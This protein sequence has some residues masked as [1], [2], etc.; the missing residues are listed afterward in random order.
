[1]K[2]S[3]YFLLVFF[4]VLF[5]CSSEQEEDLNLKH[6][7]YIANNINSDLIQIKNE[8]INLSSYAQHKIPFDREINNW[9]SNKYYFKNG[10]ILSSKYENSNSAVYL[11]FQNEISN[12]LKKNIV[13][14]E[15]LDTIFKRSIE[16]NALLTQVY[17]LDTNS[18]LRIY[19]FVDVHSYLKGS[20]DLREFVPYQTAYNK[21]FLDDNVYWIKRP[22]ADPYGRGWIIAC[23]EPLYYRERFIGIISGNITLRSL[24]EKYFSSDTEL[25][26]LADAEGKSICYTKQ[27]AKIINIPILR[28]FQY[29]KPVTKDI[30]TFTSPS[31][32]LHKNAD[33][34]KAIKSLLKGENKEIFYVDNKKY[35]IYKSYIKETNWVL[36]K[37]IN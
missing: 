28:E 34:R 26:L 1:M 13:N 6:L 5:S 3:F 14:S 7:N 22:F 35:I 17:F 27:A 32:T 36:F 24:Q 30:F 23:V 12:Q 33:L 20:I 10:E 31:L 19:P 18:F 16:R 37:I 15:L 25:M 11:P 8:I 9:P 2:R 21:P 4:S 29:F